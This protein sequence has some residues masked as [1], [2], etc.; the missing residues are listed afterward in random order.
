MRERVCDEVVAGGKRANGTLGAGNA[1]AGTPGV[2]GR[3]SAGPSNAS[4]GQN[5]A[6]NGAGA[7]DVDRSRDGAEKEKIKPSP[8]T[9]PPTKPG[10]PF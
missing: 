4:V 3:L 7:N 2:G 10:S 6:I 5:A 1:A 8:P 9:P